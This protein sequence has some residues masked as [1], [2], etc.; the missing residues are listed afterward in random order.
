MRLTASAVVRL[1]VGICALTGPCCAADLNVAYQWDKIDLSARPDVDE[2]R[3]RYA[4]ENNMPY[5]LKIWNGALFVAVPRFRRGVPA[6][7]CRSRD[8][9]AMRP[10]PSRGLQTVGN[11]LAV[12]NVKDMDV[13]HLGQ[14]WLLDVGRVHDADPA[15]PADRTC[16]PKLFVVR[17]DTGAVIRSAVMP[18]AVQSA[19]SVLTG[20]AI[21]LKTLTAVVADVGAADPGFI[22]YSLPEGVYRKYRCAALSAAGGGTGRANGRYDEAQLIVSPIDGIL[23]FTTV[24]LDRLYAVPLSVLSAPPARDVGHHVHD[25]GPKADASTAMIM[26]TGGN[27]Y[28]GM[29]RKVIAWN[30]V[31]HGFDVQELYIQVRTDTVSASESSPH[32]FRGHLAK[33][34]ISNDF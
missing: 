10:F 24:R 3:S 11:C 32:G 22:V 30:T 15:G 33:N 14:L 12:Q 23:Y 31:R 28:L 34:F 13:D 2:D 20:M 27:L 6:T 9:A 7:L 29:T 1:A 5:R 25:H 21:D 18:T 4:P 17:A 16:E 8:G 26:D 19:G